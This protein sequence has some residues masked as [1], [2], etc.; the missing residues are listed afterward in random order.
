MSLNSSILFVAL[1][2]ISFSS[3]SQIQWI[4]G[5]VTGKLPDGQKE[6]LYG[7]SVYWSGTTSGVTTDTTGFFR[8]KRD[9][10]TNQLVVRFI[11]YVSDTLTVNSDDFLQIEL[12]QDNQLEAVEVEYR[13]KTTTID[14]IS[15]K[16][17]ETIGERELLK[18][19]CCNLSES[20]ET[21][22]SV[23]VS[24]T[25]AVTGTREIQM[26]GLA[27]PYTQIMREN[28]P[29][30]RGLSAIQGMTYTPGTWVEAIQLNKGT[31]SVVNG[32]ESIA[33]QINVNLRNPANMDRVYLNAYAN[34][35]G[36][37][38]AN[39]NFSAD[40]G[41]KWGTALLLHGN[42]NQ[43]RNDTNDDGFLDNPL[44][45]H[46][47]G[48]NRWELY[49]DQG[50]H[51]QFGSKGTFINSI[52]GQNDFT[53]ADQGSTSIWGMRMQINKMDVWTKIGKVNP[54]KPYESFG[55]QISG[56]YHD[57]ETFFGLRSFDATHSMLYG[58]FIFQSI[59]GST[60]HQYKTGLSFQYDDY[61]EVFDQM[62]YDRTE[63]VPGGFF[64]Y[65]FM[66]SEQFDVIAGIRG[67]YHNL[68]GPFVTPRLH[69]RY[70]LTENTVLRGSAGRGQRTANV[71]AENMG[72]MASNRVF[73]IQGDGTNKPYGLDAEVAWNYGLNLTHE[74]TLDYKD[75]S[76]T[77]DFYRTD[78]ENQIV[79]DLDESPQEV[80]FYNLSGESYSNSFQAQLD[81]EL[82]K[83]LDLRMAYRWFDV[84]TT[85]GD[86]LLK[87]PLISTHRAF[88][89]LGYETRDHWRFD[90]T[91]N[92]QGGKRI[93]NTSSNP[94]PYKLA[95]T[96]PDF[97]LMNTQVSKYWRDEV[98]EIYVGAE[99]LLNFRQES[100]IISSEMPFSSYFDSSLIWG[101]IFG[102][103]VYLG[104]RYRIR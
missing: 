44:S 100:P 81:Y 52:G 10:K 67:D 16:K 24:F 30:V 37:L 15:A 84:Q 88:A 82:V 14:F 101:P 3:F 69:L 8:L 28:M 46:F 73:D 23:D 7:A 63:V 89:N 49:N 78:F 76:V 35:M 66:G 1:I 77:F 97:I 83:R 4:E 55:I 29:D 95:E 26:L 47:I 45:R 17:V 96:S 54:E 22:P 56:S 102:R 72:L 103:N 53:L 60:N 87:K 42:L 48:L 34:Q 104:L 62:N 21:T 9:A 50:L 61:L 65:S 70:L 92:W 98:F 51:L 20:F 93:P 5:S 58:N 36:R 57:Q 38:E 32:Y 11:G 27:G 43:I 75:G 85:Y 59:M 41:D 86:Q 79:V 12:S 39:A 18:A 94:E 74:F 19:A 90:Y 68:Y 40:V 13:Q 91:I 71:L 2:L 64:E 33:G 25:D 80:Q 31:G 6:K 99:N